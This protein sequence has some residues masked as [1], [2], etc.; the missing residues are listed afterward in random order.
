MIVKQRIFLT[1]FIGLLMAFFYW[2]FNFLLGP[3]IICL[4]L[5]ALAAL[6][7][8][9]LGYNVAGNLYPKPAELR[10]GDVKKIFTSKIFWLALVNFLIVSYAGIF[11]VTVEPGVAEE[12]VN[13]NW[14]E[15]GQALISLALIVIRKTDKLEPVK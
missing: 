1:L 4:I 3:G 9:Q 8:T 6:F 7:V 10:V 5:L 12:I 11:D 14:K 2:L 13:L 15:L